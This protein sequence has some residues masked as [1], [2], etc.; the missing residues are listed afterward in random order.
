M[1]VLYVTSLRPGDGKTAFCAGLSRLLRQHG[2]SHALLKPIRL[3]S[4]RLQS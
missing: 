2:H 4:A 3:A 1:G